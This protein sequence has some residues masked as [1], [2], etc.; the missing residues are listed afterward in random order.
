MS[1]RLTFSIGENCLFVR[2]GPD[3]YDDGDWG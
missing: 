3:D 2:D 1:Q